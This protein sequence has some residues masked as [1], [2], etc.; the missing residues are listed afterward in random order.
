MDDC[1]QI[2][3]NWYIHALKERQ[4]RVR[5]LDAKPTWFVLVA[6]D[7]EFKGFLWVLTLE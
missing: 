1:N 3:Q 4:I 2:I 7:V 6:N 5:W